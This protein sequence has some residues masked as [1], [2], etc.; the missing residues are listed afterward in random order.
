MVFRSNFPVES[1][2]RSNWAGYGGCRGANIRWAVNSSSLV[3][4]LL[5][6]NYGSLPQR[7]FSSSPTGVLL[8]PNGC[9][10]L[11]QRFSSSS[12]GCSPLPKRLFSSSPTLVL[13]FPNSCSPLPQWLFSFFQRLFPSS[14][15]D[16]YFFPHEFS[17]VLLLGFSCLFFTC[18]ATNSI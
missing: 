16:F 7:L 4:V 8:F 5:L 10:P 14:P 12:N 6:P 13:F 18:F 15:K 3:A 17:P 11:P 2:Q 9:S 1:L